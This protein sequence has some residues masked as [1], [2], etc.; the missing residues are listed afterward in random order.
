MNSRE[1]FSFP[2]KYYTIN[3]NGEI[4]IFDSFEVAKEKN[5]FFIVEQVYW[6]MHKPLFGN[7]LYPLSKYKMLNCEGE[8]FQPQVNSWQLV[9]IERD[10]FVERSDHFFGLLNISPHWDSGFTIEIVDPNREMKNF[11]LRSVQELTIVFFKVAEYNN[12]KELELMEENKRLKEKIENLEREV[13]RL[14]QI[15]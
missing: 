11:I 3:P 8:I 4:K 7:K 9:S 6:R 14:N 15:E 12:W 13:S 1:E 5:P 2:T 10:Y